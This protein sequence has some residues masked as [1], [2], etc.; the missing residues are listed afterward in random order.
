MADSGLM[1]F[2]S[3]FRIGFKISQMF[4]YGIDIVFY[5]G[6]KSIRATFNL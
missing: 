1:V 4:F 5:A 3:F 6:K 2:Y